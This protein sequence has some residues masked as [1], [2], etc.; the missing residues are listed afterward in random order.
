MLVALLFQRQREITGTLV[1]LPNSTAHRSNA[2]AEKKVT[3]A[4][5]A[6][7]A[8]SKREV[9]RSSTATTTAAG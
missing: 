7:S 5:D 1:E 8:R 6:E 9:L 2:R 3:E 4:T